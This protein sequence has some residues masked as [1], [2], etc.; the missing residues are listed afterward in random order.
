MNKAVVR[1]GVVGGLGVMAYGAYLFI[2]AGMMIGGYSTIGDYNECMRLSTNI[3]DHQGEV[4]Q[5][6][7]EVQKRLPAEATATDAVQG[8]A[9]VAGSA[10]GK[11]TSDPRLAPELKKCVGELKRGLETASK[12]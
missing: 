4:K 6:L 5:F 1:G 11:N 7:T 8:T 3:A 9:E 10:V 2:S 12:S